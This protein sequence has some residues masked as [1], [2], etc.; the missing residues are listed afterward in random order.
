MFLFGE[1]RGFDIYWESKVIYLFWSCVWDFL[2]MDVI[3]GEVV[4]F[5]GVCVWLFLM[6]LLILGLD[7]SNWIMLIC[8]SLLVI[9]KG[10]EDVFVEVGRFGEGM[11]GELRIKV[12]IGIICLSII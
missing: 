12:I 9:C 4:Y 8:F 6:V 5:K 7:R 3:L 1:F 2:M 11:L 10:V